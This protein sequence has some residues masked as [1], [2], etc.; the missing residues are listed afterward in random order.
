MDAPSRSKGATIMRSRARAAP[1]PPPRPTSTS[2]VPLP[3]DSAYSSTPHIRVYVELNIDAVFAPV[4][5]VGAWPRVPLILLTTSCRT[6]PCA[7]GC[8]RCRTRSAI[9]SPGI[10]PSAAPSYA[11]TPAR[12]SASSGVV[13]AGAGSLMAG[14]ERS[15]R[16]SAS[17][18]ATHTLPPCTA[19]SLRAS[20]GAKCGQVSPPD[21]GGARPVPVASSISSHHTLRYTP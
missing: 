18:I 2:L 13:G 19:T 17:G 11:S 8:S 7:S 4:A 9:A 10:T 21:D 3:P 16:S 12:S 14:A 5:G 20:P 1:T 6:S 15:R